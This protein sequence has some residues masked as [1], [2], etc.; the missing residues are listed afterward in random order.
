MKRCVHLLPVVSFSPPGL[1]FTGIYIS[2]NILTFEHL[3]PERACYRPGNAANQYKGYQKQWI[4]AG[5]N[6]G[7]GCGYLEGRM[8]A[9][10]GYQEAS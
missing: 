8:Q 6:Q 7:E 1:Y 5:S 3:I 9:V 2:L 4:K 10:Q